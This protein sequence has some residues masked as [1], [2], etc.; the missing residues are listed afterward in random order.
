MSHVYPERESKT[1]EFKSQVP[2]FLS[3]IKTCVAF[4]NTAGGSIIIGVEDNDRKIVGITDKDRR[5]LYDDFPNSLYDSTSP[6]ILAHIYEKNLGDSSIM[7]IEVPF[8][9]KRPVYIKKEGA[10][11]G[12][13]L[14]VGTSNRRA[15]ESHIKSLIRESR[16]HYHDGEPTNATIDDLSNELLLK[17]YGKNHSHKKLLAEFV[18]TQGM[19]DK[20]YPVTVAGVLMF[21][22]Y[23]DRYIPEANIL[24]TQFSGTKGRNIISTRQL[25]GPIPQL[26]HESL[27]LVG[28]WLEK[29]FTLQGA[30]L[31][32]TSPVPQKALREA[33]MNALLH[34]KYTI[35]GAVKI[36]LYDDRL[37][38]FS[39]GAFPGLIDI[40]NLGDGTSYLRNPHLARLAHRLHLV[41]KLG[42]G[43]KLIFEECKKS[44]IKKPQYSEDGDYVK[45]TFEFTP[46]MEAKKTDEERILNLISL[47]NEI[48]VTD[49]ISLLS[50]SRNTATRKLNK[51]ISNNSIKRVGKGPSVRYIKMQI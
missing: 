1:L 39:P 3:L 32:G 12:V 25:D 43:I 18:L 46:D 21:A 8:S 5:R 17:C 34:R 36:A 49:V 16:Y 40:K 4:A 11:N 29:H 44:G 7:I 33:I 31:T 26:I 41:E 9:P 10:S 20:R 27:Q 35:P 6:G 48:N 22:E 15:D 2:S 28:N 13:Y 37:E 30:M 23:P 24:C 50:V 19:N 45:I 42:T 51:L 38:I 14:R 47:R